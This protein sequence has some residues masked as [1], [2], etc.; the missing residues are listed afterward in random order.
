MELLEAQLFSV[1]NSEGD[2]H[3]TIKL[4]I[5]KAQILDKAGLTQKGFSLSLRAAALAHRA[6]YLNLLYDAVGAVAKVLCSLNEFDGAIQLLKAIIPQIL[7]TEDSE[8]IAQT[9]SFLADAH[10]GLAGRIKTS[11]AKRKEQMNNVLEY[12][13]RAFDEY[14]RF[15]HVQGQCEVLAKKATIMHLNGDLVLANDIAS[16][17]LAIRRAAH[18]QAI[19]KVEVARAGYE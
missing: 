1:K 8:L 6:R 17:Y 13:D 12:L 4:M 10:M 16:K 15:E 11:S 3:Q 14:S 19:G 5:L 9:F 18:E 7:E 2:V